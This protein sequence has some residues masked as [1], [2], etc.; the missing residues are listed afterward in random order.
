[1]PTGCLL[2]PSYSADHPSAEIVLAE[3]QQT[4]PPQPQA[5]Q[6]LAQRAEVLVDD[7]LGAAKA[8]SVDRSVMADHSSS[9]AYRSPVVY[10]SSAVCRP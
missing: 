8:V 6:H 5:K 7:L 4:C 1:M 3:E 10:R 9:A 2:V